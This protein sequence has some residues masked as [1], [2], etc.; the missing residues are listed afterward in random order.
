MPQDLPSEIHSV[1]AGLHDHLHEFASTGFICW[2]LIRAFQAER[3]VQRIYPDTVRR[4]R[5][6][7]RNIA[8]GYAELLAGL[9]DGRFQSA[10]G[11]TLPSYRRSWVVLQTPDCENG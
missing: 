3:H 11:L 5:P 6:R 10:A 2:G 7:F 9:P 4:D 1:S 8:F